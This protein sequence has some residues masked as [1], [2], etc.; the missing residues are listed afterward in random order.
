MWFECVEGFLELCDCGFVVEIV[1]D[2]DF[3]W[4]GC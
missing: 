1:I 4:F 2:L 3:D